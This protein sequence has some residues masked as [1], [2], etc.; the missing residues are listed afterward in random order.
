MAGRGSRRGR[1]HVRPKG[2]RGLQWDQ[3][4]GI[5]H[6]ADRAGALFLAEDLP[7]NSAPFPKSNII[8]EMTRP[9]VLRKPLRP[10]SLAA[11]WLYESEVFRR[12]NLPVGLLFQGGTQSCG[13]GRCRSRHLILGK[14]DGHSCPQGLLRRLDHFLTARG[15][16]V[17]HIR[18]ESLQGSVEVS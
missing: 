3:T 1:R 12:T 14:N 18:P 13:I 15:Q 9:R 5:A 2:R 7:A 11:V 6:R 17:S 4:E 8:S 16:L 10:S